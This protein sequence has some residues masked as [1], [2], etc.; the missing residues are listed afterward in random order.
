MDFFAP[1]GA[2]A[3]LVFIG[4]LWSRFMSAKLRRKV[5]PLVSILLLR[6]FCAIAVAFQRATD[7]VRANFLRE[8]HKAKRHDPLA[9][10]LSTLGVGRYAFCFFAFSRRA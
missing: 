7:L 8:E 4:A 1:N 9:R 10:Y 2:T 3:K 5:R 6:L